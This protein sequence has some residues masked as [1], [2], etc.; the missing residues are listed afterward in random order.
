MCYAP[1]HLLPLRARTTLAYAVAELQRDVEEQLKALPE[2]EREAK[3]TKFAVFVGGYHGF[4][5]DHA[6]GDR[7]FRS[8]QQDQGEGRRAAT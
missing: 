7:N 3:R 5:L 2:A 4:L 6:R 8:A 1:D